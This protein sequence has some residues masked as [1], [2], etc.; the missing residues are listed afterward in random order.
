MNKQMVEL[1]ESFNEVYELCEQQNELIERQNT[2]LEK[3]ND[4]IRE[5][6]KKLSDAQAVAYKYMGFTE[7][8]VNMLDRQMMHTC[9]I[10]TITASGSP[11]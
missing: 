6:N 11:W 3:Q 8:L 5:Q 10:G 1:V 4:A 7:K 9:T 2:T